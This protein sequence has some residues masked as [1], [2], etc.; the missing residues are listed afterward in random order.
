MRANGLFDLKNRVAV[1]TGGYGHLGKYFCLA[2]AQQG[3]CVFAAG[4][5]EKKF[6]RAFVHHKSPPIHFQNIDISCEESVKAAFEKIYK[7]KKRIDILVNNA[8]YIKGDVPLNISEEDWDYGIDGVLSSIFRCIK[9]AVPYMKK[10][11]EASIVNIASMYGLVSPDFGIYDGLKKQLSP[12]HYGA[13]KAGV[14]QLT[15]YLA[16]YLAQY[17]IRVNCI[18]P[19]AFPKRPVD[20]NFVK[21]LGKKIP[22]GRTGKPEELKGAVQFLASG[23][24]SYM[25]GQNMIIDGG[26]TA[27]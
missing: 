16:V 8:F 18:S 6:N 23:A 24:S 14:I 9:A 21:R 15:R 10:T 5:D 11:K 1:V 12:P 25:T 3:A 2:L 19:G 17:G 7:R 22:M 4:R 13:A 27:W 26:W 20:G